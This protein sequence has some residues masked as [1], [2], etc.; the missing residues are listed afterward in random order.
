MLGV[1]ADVPKGDA[2]KIPDRKDCPCCGTVLRTVGASGDP[3]VAAVCEQTE[4][5]TGALVKCRL[6]WRCCA[7]GCRWLHGQYEAKEEGG[8]K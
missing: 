8:G 6:F 5:G 3:N 1:G 4:D 2:M 7:C